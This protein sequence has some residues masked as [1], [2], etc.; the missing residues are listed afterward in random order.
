MIL[1]RACLLHPNDAASLKSY[2]D[3][4]IALSSFDTIRNRNDLVMDLGR[5]ADNN[6]TQARKPLTGQEVVR[7]RV[8]DEN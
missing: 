6:H 8:F 3:I 5:C 7:K 4:T 2:E 1:P